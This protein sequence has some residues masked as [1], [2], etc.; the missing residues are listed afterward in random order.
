MST[1]LSLATAAGLVLILGF[2]ILYG[3][4]LDDG[5]RPEELLGGDLITHQYAQVEGR[6]ANAPGYPLYTMGGWLWFHALSPTLGGLLNPTQ[7][8]SLYSTFWA[9]LSL[10]ILYRLALL[11]SGGREPIA[12]A[13]TAA[14][15][16]TYF[17]W[18]YAVSTE[19]YT[20]AVFQTLLLVWLA[21][22]WETT[23][24]FRLLDAMA[25]VVGTCAAN[26]VTTLVIVLPLVWFV[27]DRE[28]RLRRPQ[29]S[30]L[31]W[32]GL[33]MLPLLAYA[34]VYIRG[35]QHPEWRG[36]GEWSSTLAWFIDFLSTGQGRS[37]LTLSPFP[38]DFSYL[39]LVIRELTWPG[40][41][42]GVVGVALLPRRRALLLLSTL[43]L[44][45]AL[46]YVDRNGNWFQI[47]M[48]AYALIYLGLASAAAA[49]L[50]CLP[51]GYRG[52]AHVGL[53]LAITALAASRFATSYPRAD[54]SARPD[55]TALCPGQAILAD[56]AESGHNGPVT[57]LTTYDVAVSLQY[58]RVVYG[59]GTRLSTVTADGD[60]ALWLSRDAAGMADGM[61][62][63]IEA[64]GPALLG[65]PRPATLGA[66][67][68]LGPLRF[69][70]LT[71]ERRLADWR[72]GGDQLVVRLRWLAATEAEGVS[73]SVRPTLGEAYLSVGDAP[74]QEDHAPLWGLVPLDRLGP[75]ESVADAYLV[76]LPR[77][78]AFD[79]VALIA[80][81]PA[82][83]TVLAHVIVPLDKMPSAP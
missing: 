66:V 39:G 72:C 2:T 30:W 61:L 64:W 74:V 56:L 16:F 5:L 45:L 28:P 21:W 42:A 53:V 54:L 65:P 22:R 55:D 27:L 15:G 1:R 14:Y 19:Q 7:V 43:A 3:L 8:I 77:D 46:S 58:L 67:H 62:A 80:Y 17:F 20:S 29:Q 69:S 11:A 26:L 75:G 48:P 63:S 6:F 52:W 81:H 40:L 18:Y 12:V 78:M 57:V 73:V 38:I 68:D 36:V 37:E 32:I 4:T 71:A 79:G 9:L 47:V 49:L 60:G 13:A 76:R 50:Q 10:A 33:A 44:Y 82:D 59:Q 70:D 31:R 51:T 25:L 23:G 41:I 24:H 35:A 83:S 34:Y